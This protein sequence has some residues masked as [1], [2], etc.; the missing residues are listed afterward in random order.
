MVDSKG[1]QKR[2][3]LVVWEGWVEGTSA[4]DACATVEEAIAKT[5]EFVEM[6][7]CEVDD[8]EGEEL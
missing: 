1:Q 4:A 8:P 3:Y 5:P 7:D 2:K 6:D